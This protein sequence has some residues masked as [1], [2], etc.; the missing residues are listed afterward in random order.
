M[1][2][3]TGRA[4]KLHPVTTHLASGNLYPSDLIFPLSATRSQEPVP[5]LSPAS[6]LS[7]FSDQGER[8]L[9]P[10]VSPAYQG[11]GVRG[12]VYGKNGPG[13]MENGNLGVGWTVG[14]ILGVMARG[15]MITKKK[16]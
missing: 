5:V 1:D 11:S 14:G 2:R 4:V 6:N 12:D 13:R 16:I 3:V 10:G 9:A 7:S 8:R 15:G